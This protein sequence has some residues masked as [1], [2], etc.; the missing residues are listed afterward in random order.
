MVSI[1]NNITRPHDLF[2]YNM[3]LKLVV[4]EH[5]GRIQIE[6]RR[7]NIESNETKETQNIQLN[8]RSSLRHVPKE[9]DISKN[10]LHFIFKMFK[11]HP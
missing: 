2:N 4:Y 5:M 10:R 7:S 9:L 11:L 1:I 3:F 8:P 6:S